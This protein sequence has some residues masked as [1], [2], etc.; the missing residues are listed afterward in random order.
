MEV[1]NGIIERLRY[2]HS[3]PA[4][5]G[6]IAWYFCHLLLKEKSEIEFLVETEYKAEFAEGHQVTL[7][8]KNK[9][10]LACINHT[11]NEKHGIH[12]IIFWIISG[13][14]VIALS[15]WLFLQDYRV[16]SAAVTL[17]AL[18]PLWKIYSR[19]RIKF[20]LKKVLSE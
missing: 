3:E 2:S 14:G 17:Y 10:V 9:K 20:I 6:S 19:L 7:I 5:Y 1:I 8:L 15:T 16:L 18:L 11:T 13:A 4:K 12:G